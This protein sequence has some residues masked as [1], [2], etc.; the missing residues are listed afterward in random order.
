MWASAAASM[1]TMTGSVTCT[2]ATTTPK[3]V[4]ISCRGFA[5]RPAFSSIE[6]RKPL[7]PST[8]IQE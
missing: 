2:S 3:V 4:N 6:F 1:I 8:M 7:L 5:I